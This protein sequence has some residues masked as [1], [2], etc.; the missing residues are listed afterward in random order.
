MI[1]K[2]AKFLRTVAIFIQKATESG[3]LLT[4]G[5]AWRP[6]VTAN[7]YEKTGKGI[8]NSLHIQRLAIDLNA[9]KDGEYLDGNQEWHIPLLTKLGQIWESLDYSCAWGGRFSNR[10][11]N[12]YSFEHNGIR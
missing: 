6:P 1:E 9:F 11:Y 3:Y 2:Q 10:D 8:A 12:H 4:C 5:E 7:F